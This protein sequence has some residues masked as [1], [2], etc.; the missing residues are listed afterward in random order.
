MKKFAQL[1]KE[2][3]L[4]NFVLIIRRMDNSERKLIL[5]PSGF[6]GRIIRFF[7]ERPRGS[8]QAEKATSAKIIGRFL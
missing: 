3:S 2:I 7:L 5:I 1:F 4:H 8:H 6:T